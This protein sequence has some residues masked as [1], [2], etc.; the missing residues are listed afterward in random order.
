MRIAVIGTGGIGGPYGAALAQAGADVTF[1]ARGTHLAAI[2]ANGLHIEGDRG[3]TH[4][5]PAPATDNIAEIG[6]VDVVLCCVKL[7]DL[8]VVAEQIRAIVGPQTAVISL[9]NGIDAAQRL[10]SIL[11]NEAV[12]GGMA[13]VTGTII[14]PGVIRQT[15]AYQRMTFGELDGR[16][17]D[18][19]KRL[20][21]LCEAGGF[22]GVLSPDIVVPIW[23]KFVMLVPLS[24][25]NALTR[26]PLGKWRDDPDLLALYEA[27]LRETVSVGLAEGIRLPPNSV[28]KTFAQMRS[29]P[30]HH[31]TSMGNDLIRGNRLELPWFAGKVAELGR[32]HGIKTPANGF[33]YA[34]LKPY[35]DGAP[36]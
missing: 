9:Q 10:T 11:G 15:G 32:R 30:P 4:I 35:V 21:D 12:M 25:V 22:E 2:R 31:T 18:R 1:V 27:A 6:A 7:W 28:D 26:L 5:R 8:E 36:A 17:S 20:R 33:I 29:M 19:G 16:V 34:A 14:A 23:E 13:F 24:G 3:E